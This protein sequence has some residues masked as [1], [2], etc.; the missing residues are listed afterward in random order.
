[1]K[2]TSV[3]GLWLCVLCAAFTLIVGCASSGGERSTANSLRVAHPIAPT[4]IPAAAMA[5]VRR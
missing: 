1:M 4:L 5:P 3:R 2:P